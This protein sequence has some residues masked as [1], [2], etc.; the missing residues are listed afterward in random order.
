MRF[1]TFN[2]LILL[3]TISLS[4]GRL[5]DRAGV[6]SFFS[7]TPIEDIE[8]F[9]RQAL[10]ALNTADGSVAVSLLMKG[11]RFEKALM[12]EHFN[13]NYIESDRYPKATFV[14]RIENYDKE[15]FL[16]EGSKDY[17]VNGDMTIH[18]VTKPMTVGIQV[19]NDGS[20][21]NVETKFIVT[22]ADFEIQ[23]P[24]LMRDNIAKQVTV[25]SSFS[26]TLPK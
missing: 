5:M 1:L 2:A 11:F 8:A 20:I 9:N 21:I 18:G 17:V 15:L 3:A 16:Q 23:I 26:F 19:S 4:Q 14:G 13:E 24:R 25:S 22:V 7:T 10:G 6:A 12:E